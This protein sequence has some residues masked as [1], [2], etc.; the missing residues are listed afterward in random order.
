MTIIYRQRRIA[1][2]RHSIDMYNKGK[3]V[4]EQEQIFGGIFVEGNGE[5]ISNGKFVP[6]RYFSRYDIRE[7]SNVFCKNGWNIINIG[8]ATKYS[9]KGK[10][11]QVL[12]QCNCDWVMKQK[13]NNTTMNSS[14]SCKY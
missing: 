6:G 5:S 3:N 13:N 2:H 8:N 4:S 10:W 9:R 1:A 11:I 14:N 7:L 12:C